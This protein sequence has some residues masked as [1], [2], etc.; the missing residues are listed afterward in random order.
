MISRRLFKTKV[1]SRRVYLLKNGLPVVAFLFA[2]VLL[3]WPTVTMQK[4]RF[5]LG[6]KPVDAIK[7]AK[8]DMAQVRFYALDEKNQPMTVVAQSV[9]ETD[10]D[11]EIITLTEPQATYVTESNISLLSKTPTGYAFQKEKHLYFDKKITTTTDDGWVI[12]SSKVVYDYKDGTL[13]SDARV[14]IT[15]P[16]GT[17]DAEGFHAFNRASNINFKGKTKTH[18]VQNKENMDITTQNGLNIDQKLQTITGIG[19]VEAVQADKKIMA[20]R[21]VAHYLTGKQTKSRKNELKS[22]EAFGHVR[23]VSSDGLRKITGDKGVYDPKTG[24]VTMTGNVVLTQGGNHVK[25]DRATLNLNKS[26]VQLTSKPGQ[27]IKG[28]IIPSDM[29]KEKLNGRK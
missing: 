11:K 9:R 22:V 3:I 20:D 19:D 23:A 18:I 5:S 1:H 27:R 13:D 17:L 10:P 28:A 16:S 24:V 12:L 14:K 15:G 8:V 29:E 25:S 26:T 7:G 4:D 21:M 2:A 6:V